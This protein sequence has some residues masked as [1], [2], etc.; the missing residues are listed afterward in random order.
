MVAMLFQTCPFS[1]IGAKECCAGPMVGG[2]AGNT[3]GCAAIELVVR[4]CA[5]GGANAPTTRRRFNHIRVSICDFY[6]FG[7]SINVSLKRRFT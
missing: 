7:T 3:A 6:M 2:S 5:S 4:G 1:A